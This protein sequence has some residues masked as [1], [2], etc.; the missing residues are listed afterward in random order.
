MKK[1]DLRTGMLVET[2][3]GNL[4]LVM[5]GIT[6]NR[7]RDALVGDGNGSGTTWLPLS[8][9]EDDLS[10]RGDQSADI[11][12]VYS[13]SCNRDGARFSKVGREKLWERD[14]P[15][16]FKLTSDYDAKVDFKLSE[17]KVGCQT[18][19]F[20]KVKELALLI[21]KPKS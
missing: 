12:A 6:N 18:I 5:L 9:L 15:I 3:E 7:N 4:S 16:S 20:S 14:E 13:F 17:I 10:Y 21:D 19:P 2:R 1:S 11:M 8:A